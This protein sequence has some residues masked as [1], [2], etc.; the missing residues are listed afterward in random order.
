MNTFILSNLEELIVPFLL[1]FVIVTSDLL[2]ILLSALLADLP[3]LLLK[4]L[5]TLVAITIKGLSL[6]LP[7]V[8]TSTGAD[9]VAESNST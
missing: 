4:L 1:A 2:P 6:E 8:F 7:S 5:E 9:V 3:T